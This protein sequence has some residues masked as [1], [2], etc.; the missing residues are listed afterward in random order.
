LLN[1]KVKCQIEETVAQY[2]RASPGVINCCRRSVP[3]RLP[4]LQLPSLLG[5]T[6]CRLLLS[7]RSIDCGDDSFLLRLLFARLLQTQLSR[8]FA[9]TIP[10]RARFGT[11]AMNHVP[12]T[13]KYTPA[14]KVSRKLRLILSWH[15]CR[16]A[17]QRRRRA[18]IMRHF[19]TCFS[20]E[21]IPLLLS[22]SGD[23]APTLPPGAP[24]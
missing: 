20:V 19:R 11:Q 14:S 15:L 5:W 24:L 13:S 12:P 7:G 18:V 9:G 10:M 17:L 3:N 22:G 23:A 2:S 21:S 4:W 16:P 8:V 6:L 1:F